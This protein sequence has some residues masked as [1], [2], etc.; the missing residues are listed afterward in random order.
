M[1]QKYYV[2]GS[3]MVIVFDVFV[4]IYA[5]KIDRCQKCW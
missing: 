2:F 5:I 1:L 3:F 4:N